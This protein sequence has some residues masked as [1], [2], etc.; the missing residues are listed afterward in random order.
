MMTLIIEIFLL[1][2]VLFPSSF[3]Y[4]LLSLHYTWHIIGTL[5]AHHCVLQYITSRIYS[6]IIINLQ[7]II[8]SFYYH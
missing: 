1:Y 6:V 5:L 7:K 4:T 2:F 3:L 8:F